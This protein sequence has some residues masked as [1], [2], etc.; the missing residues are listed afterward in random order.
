MKS[1]TNPIKN[2]VAPLIRNK[3][4]FEF[5]VRHPWG[6]TAIRGYKQAARHFNLHTLED[7]TSGG[8]DY[9]RLLIHKNVRKLRATSKILDEAYAAD[10]ENAIADAEFNLYCKSGVSCFTHDWK[11][12]APRED[13]NA[14][15]ELGWKRR[16]FK[17]LDK[18]RAQ[19]YKVTIQPTH[20]HWNLTP[21]R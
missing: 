18:S 1:K 20:R 17:F 8:S 3:R 16:L 7:P 6:S 21:P 2:R 12:W 10:D 11:S 5:Y 4:V 19:V 15:K 14:L 9:Y 13:Q